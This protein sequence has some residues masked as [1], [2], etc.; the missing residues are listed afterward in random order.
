M[1]TRETNEQRHKAWFPGFFINSM[2]HPVKSTGFIEYG[3]MLTTCKILQ[4]L[5]AKAKAS[6]KGSK[7]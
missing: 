6:A 5:L 1:L 2:G 4:D 7:S 3:Q